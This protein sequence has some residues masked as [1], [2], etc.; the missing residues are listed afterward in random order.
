M[1]DI[2]DD[3]PSCTKHNVEINICHIGLWIHGVQGWSL[4]GNY[5]SAAD[6]NTQPWGYLLNLPVEFRGETAPSRPRDHSKHA[7]QV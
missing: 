6:L 3:P 2:H 5:A 7:Q 1:P 4:G